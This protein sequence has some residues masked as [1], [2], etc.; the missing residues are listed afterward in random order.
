[1]T[2]LLDEGATN[3]YTY[4]NVSS[5]SNYVPGG[6]I[7]N[8]DKVFMP[9]N[10]KDTHWSLGVIF[11]KEKRIQYYDSLGWDGT[12]Y[13]RVLHEYIKDE[14]RCKKGTEMKLSGWTLVNTTMDTPKQGNGFDC[15]VFIMMFAECSFKQDRLISSSK[16]D[17]IQVEHPQ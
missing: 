13:L 10:I 11:V 15:G 17:R 5:W 16:Q 4:M 3:K 2:K 9:I 6:D 12:Y 14:W 8:L 7:F 1:M